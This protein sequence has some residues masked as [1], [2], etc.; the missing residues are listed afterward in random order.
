M[1][2][3]KLIIAASLGLMIPFMSMG[4]ST[5]GPGVTTD[6]AN[7]VMTNAVGKLAGTPLAPH[8]F[9]KQTWNQYQNVGNGGQICQ[10]CHTPHNAQGAATLGAPLWNHQLSGATYNL[11]SA[12]ETKGGVGWNLGVTAPDGTS[13]LC[14][15]CHDGTVALGA[16][17]SQTLQGATTMSVYS[18]G[19]SFGNDLSNDHPIS[20]IYQDMLSAGMGSLRTT[21]DF[22][23]TAYNSATGAYTI[24]ATKTMASMLD[25]NGK[26]QCTSCHGAHSNS[27]GYQ[28]SMSNQGSLLCLQCHKK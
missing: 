26:I 14:L 9:A 15:S 2:T 3:T 8:N 25:K 20:V 28:L 4:Q 23:P 7:S 11:Y 6:P 22:V 27:I 5:L 12:V 1:K 19:A 24:S 16:Y 10:P 18:P 17:G 21:T 13:K